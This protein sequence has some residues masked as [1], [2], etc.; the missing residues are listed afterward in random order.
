MSPVRFSGGQDFGPEIGGSANVLWGGEGLKSRNVIDIG[1]WSD[2]AMSCM[3]ISEVLVRSA[4]LH[5]R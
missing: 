3:R 1:E 2:I 5:T 4:E